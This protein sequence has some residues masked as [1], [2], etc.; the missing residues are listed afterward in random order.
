M[1]GVRMVDQALTSSRCQ[2]AARAEKAEYKLLELRLKK[3]NTIIVDLVPWTCRHKLTV[4]STFD[5]MSCVFPVAPKVCTFC[6]ASKVQTPTSFTLRA[7]KSCI[8]SWKFFHM[9]VT[10][11]KHLSHPETPREMTVATV[12]YILKAGASANQKAM[13]IDY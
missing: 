7:E 13:P 3:H 11:V 6:P 9:F 8:G 1:K 2:N 4:Q 12:L 10:Y 5:Q